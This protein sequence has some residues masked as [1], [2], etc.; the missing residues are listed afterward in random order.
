MVEGGHRERIMCELLSVHT[1]YDMVQCSSTCRNCN[2]DV[3][4][5]Q[6]VDGNSPNSAVGAMMGTQSN[7]LFN[8]VLKSQHEKG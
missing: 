1:A 4:M 7:T 8:Y 2:G 3:G 5:G 6:S